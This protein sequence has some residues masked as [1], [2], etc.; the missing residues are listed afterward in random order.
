VKGFLCLSLSVLLVAYTSF[1]WFLASPNSPRSYWLLPI[2]SFVRSEEPFLPSASKSRLSPHT[3]QAP[4][5]AVEHSKPT[6]RSDKLS[7]PTKIRESGASSTTQ[8][9][10][11]NTF[12]GKTIAYN[13]SAFVITLGWILLTS[14]A[15]MSPITNLNHLINRW[16]NSDSV[17][18]LSLCLAIGMI[19]VLLSWMHIF[20]PILL[21]LA[22][23]CLARLD[24]Q[25]TGWSPGQAFWILTLTSIVGLF[26]GFVTYNHVIVH[27]VLS[28]GW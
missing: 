23:E 6:S 15:F 28:A 18:F 14:I 20:L 12:C 10:L 9:I 16:F 5:A 27:R 13:L 8:R 3:S 7:N 24:I 21:I 19:S 22:A 17:A 1:G 25:T 11:P 2:C 4:E 26:L